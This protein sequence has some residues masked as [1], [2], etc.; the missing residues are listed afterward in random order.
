M[1]IMDIYLP[2]KNVKESEV[3]CIFDAVKQLVLYSVYLL[4]IP[5]STLMFTNITISLL[6]ILYCL[7]THKAAS[8]NFY[9]VTHAALI[10]I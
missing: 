2:N 5:S 9:K 1:I 10:I 6:H 7:L 3:I 4:I 8:I